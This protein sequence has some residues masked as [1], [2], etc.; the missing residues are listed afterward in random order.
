MEPALKRWDGAAGGP[1]VKRRSRRQTSRGPEASPPQRS[2]CSLFLSPHAHGGRGAARG[3]SAVQPIFAASFLCLDYF[4]RNPDY[5]YLNERKIKYIHALRLTSA[6]YHR[7]TARPRASPPHHQLALPRPR[8][9]P[10]HRPPHHQLAPPR[11]RA[12]RLLR[13][14]LQDTPSLSRRRRWKLPPVKP[15]V[16]L[17]KNSREFQRHH[18]QNIRETDMLFEH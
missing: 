17:T 18:K 6:A 13:S 7:A 11:P 2:A 4:L 1:T 15:T 8:A 9:R 12:H 14:A 5:I 10:P 3:L 16:L